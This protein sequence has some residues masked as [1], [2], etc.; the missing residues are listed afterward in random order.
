MADQPN[1][2]IDDEGNVS[3]EHS[4]STFE[5]IPAD[6]YDLIVQNIEV[7]TTKDKKSQYFAFEFRTSDPDDDLDNKPIFENISPKA[8]WRISQLIAAVEGEMED[9]EDG[10][11]VEF[12]IFDL[13]GAKLRARVGLE[14]IEQGSRK[15]D[16]RNNIVRFTPL[17]EELEEVFEEPP[18]AKK[19]KKKAPK[20]STAKSKSKKGAARRSSKK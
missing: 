11:T 13:F 6:D 20:K 8:G 5:P 12:N 1:Y 9:I 7:K 2:T 18:P 16:M 10:D 15:G 19:K 17:G 3:Y 14:E 4:S